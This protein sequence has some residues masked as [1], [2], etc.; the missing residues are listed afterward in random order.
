MASAQCQL[1]YLKNNEE[2]VSVKLPHHNTFVYSRMYI[3]VEHLTISPWNKNG[4]RSNLNFI[5]SC[6]YLDSHLMYYTRKHIIV[7]C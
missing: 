5:D 3:L 1:Y 4:I 6:Q 7:T 2:H